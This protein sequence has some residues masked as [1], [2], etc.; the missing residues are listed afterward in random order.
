M[1]FLNIINEILAPNKHNINFGSLNMTVQRMPNIL[2]YV[3]QYALAVSYRIAIRLQPQYPPLLLSVVSYSKSYFW[4][5][6][7]WTTWNRIIYLNL[8][9]HIARIGTQLKESS[10]IVII[11]HL[12]SRK[13]IIW[14]TLFHICCPY[15]MEQTSS[16][17]QTSV[18]C[19]FFQ[20]KAENTPLQET[21]WLINCCIWWL[22]SFACSCVSW[23]TSSS[24]LCSLIV[25]FLWQWFQNQASEM[26]FPPSALIKVLKF[27]KKTLLDQTASDSV[28]GDHTFAQLFCAL[29]E[30]WPRL[31]SLDLR[32]KHRRRRKLV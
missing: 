28:S 22:W 12:F 21:L 25:L 18:L 1:Q 19:W 3:L 9:H 16:W 4:L 24:S 14:R 31:L 6:N 8:L 29:H 17:S 23:L 2:Q 32:E 13:K 30:C 10:N 20:E 11:M 15:W 7:V 26:H 5:I 27:F